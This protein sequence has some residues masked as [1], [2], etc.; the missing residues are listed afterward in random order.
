MVA[1]M[2]PYMILNCLLSV[3]VGRMKKG[4]KRGRLRYQ[5][6]RMDQVMDACHYAGL[7]GHHGAREGE[8]ASAFLLS[9]IDQ[10][11]SRDQ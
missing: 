6:L 5:L 3:E 7:Q 9:K 10:S 4:A 1:V 8:G 11:G 2:D